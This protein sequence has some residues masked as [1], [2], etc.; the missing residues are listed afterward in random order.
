MEL[1]V[2]YFEEISVGNESRL[3]VIPNNMGCS[4]QQGRQKKTLKVHHIGLEL[5]Q[6]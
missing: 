2:I 1:K 3:E 4:Y 6:V 5:Y